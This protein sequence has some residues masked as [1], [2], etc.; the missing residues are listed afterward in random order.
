MKKIL[1]L[2]LMFF[3][4]I[5]PAGLATFPEYSKIELVTSK[6][7]PQPVRPGSEVSI[8]MRLGNTGTEEAEDVNF[9]LDVVDPFVLKS[10][11][12]A[13]NNSWDICAGCMKEKTYHLKVPSDVESGTYSLDFTIY[14]GDLPIKTSKT[15]D[16]QVYGDADL[17]LETEEEKVLKPG[18]FFDANFTINNLGTGNA[19]NIKIIPETSELVPEGSDL[20][21][22]DQISP[23]DG[24]QVFGSFMVSEDLNRDVYSFPFKI[25]YI[26]ELG[27][28]K[29]TSYNMHFNVIREADI[30][31]KNVD[32]EPKFPVQGEVVVLEG[33]VENIGQGDAENVK[34]ELSDGEVLGVYHLGQVE[35]NDDSLFYMSFKSSE[36]GRK[37]LSLSITYEDDTGSHEIQENLRLD[38]G[39]G[40]MLLPVA[41]VLIVLILA[42]VYYYKFWRDTD[43]EKN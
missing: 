31:I 42:G 27:Q 37:D 5:T 1:I 28:N 29:V 16:I 26:D 36:V 2:S 34:V 24:K 8:Q 20:R 22:I 39:G 40:S 18:D 14:R 12:V 3:L 9:K 7:T 32:M 15:V 25:E 10:T 23:G 19:Y 6:V 11:S 38:V 33:L 30:G 21:T 41:V 43:D 13:E 17:V 4:L 35:K